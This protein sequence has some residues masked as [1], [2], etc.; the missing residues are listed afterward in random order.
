MYTDEWEPVMTADSMSEKVE[1]LA[2]LASSRADS[3]DA[4][5]EIVDELIRESYLNRHTTSD[6]LKELAELVEEYPEPFYDG[7]AESQLR[8][9]LSDAA[10]LQFWHEYVFL[11]LAAGLEWA[12]LDTLE[13]L[14]E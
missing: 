14:P 9:R 3:D 10:N 7:A 4:L 2:S 1:E 5:E 11:F 13:Q 8:Q 12:V 6:A